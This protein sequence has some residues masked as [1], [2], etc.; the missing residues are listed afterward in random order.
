[1]S[2]YN[3]LKPMCKG[4]HTQA[5]FPGSVMQQNH[6]S[7]FYDAT[8]KSNRVSLVRSTHSY[9]QSL[10]VVKSGINSD[11]LLFSKLLTLLYWYKHFPLWSLFFWIKVRERWVKVLICS[12]TQTCILITC[13][14]NKHYLKGHGFIFLKN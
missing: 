14:I 5:S 10:H 13:F 2:T 3:L 12:I 1:V 9:P 8:M 6:I 7:Y 4:V 11:R